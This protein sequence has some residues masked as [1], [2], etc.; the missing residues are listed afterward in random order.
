MEL[1]DRVKEQVTGWEGILVGRADYLTGCEQW[2]VEA[3][4]EGGVP[5]AYWFDASRLEVLEEGV[6]ADLGRSLAAA[7]H[8]G[9]PAGHAPARL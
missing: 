7:A 3:M 1:G 4:G 2:L 5:K 6:H 9:G 8:P